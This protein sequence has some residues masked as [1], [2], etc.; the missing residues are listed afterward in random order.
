[1]NLEDLQTIQQLSKEKK[2]EITKTI[3]EIL[4]DPKDFVQISETSAT[5]G[6]WKYGFRFREKEFDL[7]I[8]EMGSVTIRI[9][10]GVRNPVACFYASITKTENGKFIWAD[11]DSIAVSEN[12]FSKENIISQ[13]EK[14]FI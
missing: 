12:F 10:T 13:L 11:L 7:I 1:M 9:K 14:V 8:S 6:P 2:E 3:R 4:E 5:E